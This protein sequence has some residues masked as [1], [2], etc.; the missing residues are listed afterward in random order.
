MVV[1]IKGT[2]QGT[3]K[4]KGKTSVGK[5]SIKDSWYAK[6][7]TTTNDVGKEVAVDSSGNVYIVGDTNSN[8]DV[9]IIKYNNSGTLVWQRKLSG[10][11]ST[12]NGNGIAVD[13]LGNVYIVGYTN[14]ASTDDILI[15]KYNSSGTLL[16]QTILAGSITDTGTAIAVDSSGNVYITGHIYN[17]SN[18]DIIIAKYDT[19]GNILWQRKLASNDGNNEIA[20]GIAVD[21]SGNVYITGMF[22]V[23]SAWDI[24]IAKYTTSGTIQWQRRLAGAGTDVGSGIAVD[25]SGNVYITGSSNASSNI[26]ISKYDTNGN[27][28][29]PNG[30]QRRL[31]GGY[32]GFGIAVDSSGNVYISGAAWNGSNLDI[33]IAKYNSS[34]VIQWQRTLASSSNDY[35]FGIAL[36][37]SGTNVYIAGNT[38]TNI[39]I[40]KLPADGSIVNPTYTGKLKLIHSAS[41]LSES[42]GGL[43]PSTPTLADS[44]GTL[45]SFKCDL[46]SNDP[47]LT[48][49][50]TYNKPIQVQLLIYPER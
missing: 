47:G 27:I 2:G 20:Y 23:G 28:S 9:I 39:L 42:A 32:S 25:G 19:N 22:V 13:N 7:D 12:E 33:L 36:D 10:A 44:A 50:L 15:V 29:S 37:S 14:N 26:I 41:S 34:G 17:G 4:F 43:T 49:S 46:Y 18:N 3:V 11:S 21:S 6:L 45:D 38:G 16:W 1:Q 35:G 40:A 48:H 31:E 24:L 30:W 8:T 5:T